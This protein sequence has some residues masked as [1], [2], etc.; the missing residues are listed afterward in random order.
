MQLHFSFPSYAY[1]A[2]LGQR[3]TKLT[4]SAV[5]RTTDPYLSVELEY[6]IALA[7]TELTGIYPK[8][9]EQCEQGSSNI[10]IRMERHVVSDLACI[11]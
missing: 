2:S 3:S 9:A 11:K 8:V 4:L 5:M 7:V 10:A 1:T 6:V